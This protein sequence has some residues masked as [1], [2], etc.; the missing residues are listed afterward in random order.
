MLISVNLFSIPLKDAAHKKFERKGQAK[1]LKDAKA[2]TGQAGS[3]DLVG[4]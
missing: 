3:E 1:K 2:Q 4:S